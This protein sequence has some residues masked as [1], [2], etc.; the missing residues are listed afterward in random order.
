MFPIDE[1]DTDRKKLNMETQ[2]NEL[3]RI[4]ETKDDISK[5]RGTV[6]GVIEAVA[7][8]MP[9]SAPLRNTATYQENNFMNIVDGGKKNLMD[10]ACAYFG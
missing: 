9:H 5:F 3:K 7:D 2:R 8:F 4:Y 6:Y 1:K 10:M